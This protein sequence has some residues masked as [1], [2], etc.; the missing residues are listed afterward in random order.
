MKTMSLTKK[1]I[2]SLAIVCLSLFCASAAP[3]VLAQQVPQS[4]ERPRVSTPL[5]PTELLATLRQAHIVQYG[6]PPNQAR[7]AMAWAQV[8]LENAHGAMMWNHN[9]GNVGPGRNDT[10]YRHSPSTRYRSFESFIDGAKTYWRVVT[11]CKAAIKMFD[12]GNPVQAAEY[13]HQCGYYEDDYGAF[14]ART[15][16]SLYGFALSTVIPEEARERREKEQRIREEHD[17]ELMHQF[18]P[19]CLCSRW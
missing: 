17:F 5:T 18:T 13:L 3:D 11:W 9:V 1:V 16:S 12:V 4:L 7:L 6:S 10:W 19:V 8:A 2:S 14:Y 15:M